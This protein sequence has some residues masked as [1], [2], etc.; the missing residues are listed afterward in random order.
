M[1]SSKTAVKVAAVRTKGGHIVADKASKEAA[2]TGEVAAPTAGETPAEKKSKIAPKPEGF[3]SPYHFAAE[4]KKA[5]G[6]EVRPQVI[7]GLV[8]NKPKNAKGVEFPVIQNED[9][10]FMVN[11]QE[12]LQWWKD[13]VKR[14]PKTKEEAAAETA[15][16]PS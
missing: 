1:S 16:T 13:R 5:T 6:E 10:H 12:A 15:A 3:V 14:Q 7:Y 8:R 11:V 9:G 2:A 4:L